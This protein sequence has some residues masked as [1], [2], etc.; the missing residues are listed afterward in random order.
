MKA[1]G[2]EEPLQRF[3]WS[4][5]VRHF[6]RVVNGNAYIHSFRRKLHLHSGS[7]KNDDTQIFIFTHPPHVNLL[8]ID[9]S[10]LK[11][12]LAP[13]LGNERVALK[14]VAHIKSG[15]KWHKNNHNLLPRFSL[16]PWY[17]MLTP[18]RVNWNVTLPLYI[19]ISLNL[20]SPKNYF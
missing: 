2:L 10:V 17:T 6:V 14:I 16:N 8:C 5:F 15:Q 1:T 11:T 7:S 13:V 12:L 4:F 19:S 9:S 20:F 3:W 18:T